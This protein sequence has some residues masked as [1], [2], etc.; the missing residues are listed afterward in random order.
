MLYI[1]GAIVSESTTVFM[2]SLIGLWL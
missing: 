1:R 2:R